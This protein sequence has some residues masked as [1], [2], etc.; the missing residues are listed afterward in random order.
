M[1][2]YDLDS[3][4]D[5]NTNNDGGSNMIYGSLCGPDAQITPTNNTM[6]N[7]NT[8]GQNPFGNNAHSNF[9]PPQMTNNRPVMPGQKPCNCSNK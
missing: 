6:N 4:T 2:K 9:Q 3:P 8:K 5:G 7:R 1:I